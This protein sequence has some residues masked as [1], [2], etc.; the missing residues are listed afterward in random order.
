MGLEVGEWMWDVCPQRG[1]PACPPGATSP[2]SQPAPKPPTAPPLACNH[3]SST[4]ITAITAVD[5][6]PGLASLMRALSP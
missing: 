2:P 6:A 1:L 4:L 5:S 3:G